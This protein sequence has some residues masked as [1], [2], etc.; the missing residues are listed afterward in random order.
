MGSALASS[1]Q[2]PVASTSSPASKQGHSFAANGIRASPFAPAGRRSAGLPVVQA[3]ASAA[4]SATR[5][6]AALNIADNVTQL[7]GKTPM[8]FLNK[9]RGRSGRA[10][11]AGSGGRRGPTQVQSLTQTCARFFSGA[12]PPV[13]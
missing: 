6:N 5:A 4:P 10:G 1:A 3:T 9:V 11:G 12:A 2:V 13:R 7:I 8:V